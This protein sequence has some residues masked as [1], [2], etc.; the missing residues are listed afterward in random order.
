MRPVVLCLSACALGAAAGSARGQVDGAPPAL[1]ERNSI[2]YAGLGLSSISSD[3]NNLSNAT[4]LDMLAGA[5]V[6]R[7]TWLSG[8]MAL[9]FT[10]APGNNHGP[11]SASTGGTPCSVPP[12][13]LD[14]DGTPDGCDSGATTTADPGATGSQNDLQMTNL[15]AFAVLRT[16]GPVFALA[17]Y[18]YRYINTSIAEIQH[19]D[20]TGTAYSVG[21][22]YR[23]GA[24]LSKFELAYTKYSRH[25]DYFGLGIAYGFGGLP[26]AR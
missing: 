6:P 14:P 16:P 22:G 3:F 2:F 12:S 4:N 5:H 25:L 1:E 21:A 8:E 9:S 15:G 10:V 24:G 26:T 11:R 13:L 7:L 18:G 17:R 20:Q 19:D 23:W